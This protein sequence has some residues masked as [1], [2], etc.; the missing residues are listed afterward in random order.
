MLSLYFFFFLE[1]MTKRGC[2]S[3]TVKLS[4]ITPFRVFDAK[5]L[6]DITLRGCFS[7]YNPKIITANCRLSF[8][9]PVGGSEK[10][11][12]KTKMEAVSYRN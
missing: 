5:T 6:K 8:K 3:T 2:H 10:T 4:Q 1:K 12:F 7:I 11:H 9:T